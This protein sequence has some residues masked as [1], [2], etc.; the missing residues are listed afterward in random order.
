MLKRI[1]INRC[2]HH[3]NSKTKCYENIHKLDHIR[4]ELNEIKEIVKSYDERLTISYTT[5]IIALTFTS[6]MFFSKLLVS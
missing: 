2:L 6:I 1:L 3:A 5:N 4:E